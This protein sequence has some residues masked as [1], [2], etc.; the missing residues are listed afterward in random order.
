MNTVA[1][2]LRRSSRPAL[3]VPPR[4]LTLLHRWLGIGVGFLFALWFASGAVLCFVPFPTLPSAARIAHSE[5]VDLRRVSVA[6]AAALAAA[7]GLAVERLRLISVAG[8]PRY[9]LSVTGGPVVSVSAESGKPLGPLSADA[10]RAV[11]AAFAGHRVAGVAGPFDDDQW[12]V[13]DQYDEFRPF[14][15]VALEDG[16]GTELYVSTRSGEVLQRTRRAERE[17][18]YVGSVV[19]W[20]NIVALRRH[21]DLWRGVMLALAGTCGLLA[22][23]GLTLGVIHLINTKRARR[24]GLSPFRGWLRWHHSIGLFASVLLLSWIVSG[25][26]MLDDGT[27]FPS[28]QPTAAA[29]GSFRGMTLAEA[30][31]RFSLAT[32]RMLPPARQIE[33]TAVAGTPYLSVCNGAPGDSWL[34]TPAPSGGLSLSH[35]VPDASLLAAAHAAWPSSRVL[36]IGAISFDDAYQLLSSPLPGT[37][38]R[39]VLDDDRRTWIQIDSAT[40]E[41]LSVTDSR[42][43]ARRWWVSGLHDLD[44]P[45]L[46]RA[47]PLRQILVVLAS[48][49]GFAFSLTGIVLVVKRLRR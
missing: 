47:G 2:S 28:D 26:L 29:V 1:Q 19:H 30:A 12:I 22:C 25:C 32:L 41:I 27:V 20:V 23:A 11:A 7:S 17:W 35:A 33:V 14:Y 3:F 31:D 48:A 16:R 21:K 45:L 18:N 44:F 36:H 43:R 10:A 37:A 24:S 15:R 39:V 38:R 40:G 42:G 13:H 8:H 9:V 5:P 34:A 4:S 49:V 46:D 6:P